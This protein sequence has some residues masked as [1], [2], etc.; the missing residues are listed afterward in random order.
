MMIMRPEACDFYEFDRDDDDAVIG[1][2]PDDQG[3]SLHLTSATIADHGSPDP[4]TVSVAEI[5]INLGNGYAMAYLG[6]RDAREVAQ[7]LIRWA[8][9]NDRELVA[10]VPEAAGLPSERA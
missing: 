8:D 2:A 10:R 3:G 7:W 1:G 6:S 4:C 5:G 9:W